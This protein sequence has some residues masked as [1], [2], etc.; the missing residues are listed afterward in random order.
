MCNAF[1]PIL[2][3]NG[4][5]REEVLADDTARQAKAGLGSTPSAY[6]GTV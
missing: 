1:G 4:G 2:G 3:R 6:L 5:D